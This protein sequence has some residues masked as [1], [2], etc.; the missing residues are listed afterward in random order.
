V[1]SPPF[2]SSTESI[3]STEA[4]SV[5]WIFCS[6]TG[7]RFGSSTACTTSPWSPKMMF[8]TSSWPLPL[9][10]MLSLPAFRSSRSGEAIGL[11]VLSALAM[12]LSTEGSGLLSTVAI[13]RARVRMFT[14]TP[15]SP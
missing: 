5:V 2:C 1:S 10:S 4:S 12:F 14:L 13:C 3:A 6:S 11:N 15:L 8:C 7:G 9:P